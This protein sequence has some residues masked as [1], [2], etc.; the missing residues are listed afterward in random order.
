MEIPPSEIEAFI[1]AYYLSESEIK[2][3]QKI[4]KG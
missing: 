3:N 4:P 2:F 1:A